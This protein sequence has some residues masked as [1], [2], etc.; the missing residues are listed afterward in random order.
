M[1]KE[2]FC[3]LN[4]EIRIGYDALQEKSDLAEQFE[5]NPDRISQE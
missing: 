4:I 5:G 1:F 3:L 2:K